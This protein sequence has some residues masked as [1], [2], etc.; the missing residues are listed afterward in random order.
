M[1]I[2]IPGGSG[3][4]GTILARHFHAT[5]HEV[6]VLSRKPVPAA[7]R[8]VSWDA[9]THGVWAKELDGADAVINLA[10]RNVNCRYGPANRRA[11]MESR[12]RSTQIVGEA[13][14]ACGRPPR[15]WLQASTATIYAHRFDAPNDEHTGTLGG[16]EPDAPDTW[17]FSIAVA[18][19]WEKAL[20]AVH[21]PGTRKVA[22]RSAMTMSADRDGVFDV[23]L[24]LVR[25][26]LGGRAGSGQQFVSWIHEADFI[27]AIEFLIQHEEL[28][29][30]VNVSAPEPL[31]NA[32]FMR[33][34][35]TAWG[36]RFGLPAARWMVEL[37]AWVMR[38]E[39]ELVLKS[40]RVVPGRLLEAGFRFHFPTWPEAARALCR[41]WRER[42][43]R[44]AVL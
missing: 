42:R 38:T 26:W 21:T 32:E 5:G 28:S 3:Q 16:E 6:V 11:I 12:T 9:Q 13:I 22:L 36:A 37:G 41:E 39:S 7:W 19:A 20:N 14:A 25:W 8:V 40:R 15:V 31:P 43:G 29:G 30:P 34:L 10:G 18:A 44:L 4:A 23:L 1:K 24:R 33:V 35:R 17:K 27:A 2:I